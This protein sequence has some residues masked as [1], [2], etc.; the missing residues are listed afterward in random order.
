VCPCKCAT[1][2][3]SAYLERLSLKTNRLK[4]YLLPAPPSEPR[5]QDH[6]KTIRAH[7][8]APRARRPAARYRGSVGGGT[9]TAAHAASARLAEQRNLSALCVCAYEFGERT[10]RQAFGLWL[11]PS[12]LDSLLLA[13]KPDRLHLMY[14]SRTILFAFSSVLVC[15]QAGWRR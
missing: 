12:L 9:L 8:L 6:P 10:C 11:R 14:A 15:S 4:T 1:V 7:H 2:H 5:V 13:K 3:A